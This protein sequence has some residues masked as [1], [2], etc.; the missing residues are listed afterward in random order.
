MDLCCCCCCCQSLEICL[1]SMVEAPAHLHRTPILAGSGGLGGGGTAGEVSGW[2]G[3]GA[4]E[5]VSRHLC[6]GAG[7]EGWGVGKEGFEARLGSV[8]Q[9][10][11]T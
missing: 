2:G 3:G 10:P 4:G 1:G 7:A 6:G 9:V 11:L 5:V 8:V